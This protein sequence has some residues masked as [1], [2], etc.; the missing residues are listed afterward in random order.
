ME[1][2]ITNIETQA[3]R[4][5]ERGGGPQRIDAILADLFTQYQSRFPEVRIAVVE[6]PV[7]AA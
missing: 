1:N 4:R 3:D 6:T 5:D 7:V 2:R